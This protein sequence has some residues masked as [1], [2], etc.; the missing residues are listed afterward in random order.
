M[1]MNIPAK[2]WI[3][4][5]YQSET[6]YVRAL[7]SSARSMLNADFTFAEIKKVLHL[8]DFALLTF[9]LTNEA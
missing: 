4:R 1:G 9:L 5:G 7:R 6:E 3:E 2:I 8:S